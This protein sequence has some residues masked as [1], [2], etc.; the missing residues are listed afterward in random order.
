[1]GKTLHMHV[2]VNCR[3]VYHKN[4]KKLNKKQ[5]QES[6]VEIHCQISLQLEKKNISLLH[7]IKSLQISVFIQIIINS[8]Y[9][10]KHLFF[11]YVTLTS[12]H[13]NSLTYCTQVFLDSGP[14]PLVFL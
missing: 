7:C 12:N 13:K 10:R 4:M 1:M 11:K 6:K 5:K 2:Q 3:L 14:V 9:T 8:Y